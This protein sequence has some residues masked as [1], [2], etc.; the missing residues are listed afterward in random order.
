M[1]EVGLRSDA[2]AKRV[3]YLC[4]VD[5]RAGSDRFAPPV[6]PEFK[7]EDKPVV[8]EE[9][10]API[11]GPRATLE[12]PEAPIRPVSAISSVS[13]VSTAPSESG[14]VIPP[15]HKAVI[16]WWRKHER[17]RGAGQTERGAFEVWFHGAIPRRDCEDLLRVKPIGCF[18][19]RLS[20]NRNGYTLSA[21]ADKRCK[22]FVI[23][24]TRESPSRYLLQ[25]HDY[26]TDTLSKL[27]EYYKKH[28]LDN[29]GKRTAIPIRKH[30][31]R[32]TCP[33]RVQ[34]DSRMRA[35]F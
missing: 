19:T 12:A 28:P 24:Q 18:M 21:R 26:Y 2:L 11:P 10:P 5:D 6:P 1:Q 31:V 14:R 23:E 34:I 22:H 27:I 8:D 25:G 17:K 29:K 16:R 32:I 15:E 20:T 33:A 9:P 35:A 3:A 7:R 13:M 30:C 4:Q